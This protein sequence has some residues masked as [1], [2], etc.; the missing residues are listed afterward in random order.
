[1][2]SSHALKFL[3]QRDTHR[4]V[5][6]LPQ[7]RPTIPDPAYFYMY[8]LS[9]CDIIDTLLQI[10]VANLMH[11]LSIFQHHVSDPDLDGIRLN[12]IHLL[13]NYLVHDAA[14]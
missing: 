10:Y 4:E 13:Y 7:R 12:I 2:L 8:M 6:S 3:H 5:I 1:M 9:I 14:D 11:S